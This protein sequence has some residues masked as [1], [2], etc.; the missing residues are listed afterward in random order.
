MMTLVDLPCSPGRGLRRHQLL[1]F[2]SRTSLG[3]LLHRRQGTDRSVSGCAPG[4]NGDV[5]PLFA[6]STR[7]GSTGRD[8]SVSPTGPAASPPSPHPRRRRCIRRPAPPT[9][10]HPGSPCPGRHGESSAAHSSGRRGRRTA[11][12]HSGPA[13]PLA[14]RDESAGAPE[15]YAT[16]SEVRAVTVE[17]RP[18]IGDDRVRDRDDALIDLD[19]P[20][21]SET[22]YC[23]RS[24]TDPNS[25]P[26]ASPG[27]QRYPS[28]GCS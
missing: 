20:P 15:V 2:M 24:S 9:R 23:R 19:Q 4:W 16:E 1:L 27:A 14:V 3:D 11:G 10:P 18:P 6:G 17:G 25:S 13:R 28:T 21:M 26:L 8:S 12:R 22:R 7:R 5:F